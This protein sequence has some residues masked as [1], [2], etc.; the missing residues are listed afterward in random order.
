VT[1]FTNT[2]FSNTK[3]I[4]GN[5]TVQVFC[6]ADGWARAF[7]TNK[8]HVAHETHSLLFYRDGVSNMMVMDGAKAQLQGISV[9]SWTMLDAISNIPSIILLSIIY[10]KVVCSN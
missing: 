3:S 4:V 6:T 9:G 10:L 2:M 7:P 5:K 8:E 1:C